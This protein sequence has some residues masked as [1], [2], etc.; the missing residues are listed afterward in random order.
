[1]LAG[2]VLGS[3]FPFVPLLILS[4]LILA[5]VSVAV[6]EGRGRLTA[7]QGTVLYGG[8]LAGILLWTASTSEGTES[9]LAAFDGQEAVA[10]T[11]T[12]AEP[13]RYAPARTVLVLSSLHFGEGAEPQAVPGKLRVTWREPDRAFSPGD[14][15]HL[16]ARIHLPSGTLNPGGFDYGGY[17]LRLG[18]DAVASVSGAGRVA[19]VAS[20]PRLSRWEPW[21][22]VEEWRGRIRDAALRTLPDPARGIYL[23]IIIGEQGYLSQD[24]RDAFMATGTV[25][26]LSI[27]GSHLGLVAWLSFFFVQGA[28]RLLPARWLLALSRRVTPTRLAAAA[29]IVLAVFYTLLAG[30]EVA[31]VRSLVMVAMFL[32][33]VWLGRARDLLRAVACAALLIVAQNPR[34]LFDISFQLSYL[35]ALTIALVVTRRSGEEADGLP[36][37]SLTPWE[38]AGRWAREYLWLTGGVTLATLPLVAYYFKQIAW[39]GLIANAV[40]VPLAGFVLVPLGLGSAVWLL[41]TGGD[42]LPA[43]AANE[44]MLDVFSGIV[45]LFAKLPGAEWHV[46]SPAL[47]AVVVFYGL[48]WM[49]TR[50]ARERQGIW[51]RWAGAAGV[52]V[53]LGWWAWSPRWSDGE[54]L[55][56]TFLDVGQGDACVL[57]LPDG[58][59]AL[60]DGGARYDTL[61]MGRAVVAPYLWERGIARLDHV[62]ATHPQLDHVGGLTWIV[63]S[64]DVGRYW[65]NGVARD[66][67]FYR[68]L[69]DV[70]RARGLMNER[71][72]EGRLV[73]ESGPCRLGILN[74]PPEPE[75]RARSRGTAGALSGSFLND[76]SVVATLECGVHS[77]LFTADVETG[78]L[79]RLH[80]RGAVSDATVVKVPHHGAASSLHE[81]WISGLKA[82][83]AIV[84]VGRHNAYGHP[85][86]SVVAAYERAGITLWR[87]DRDGA[88]WLTGRLSDPEL[89]IRTA[90]EYIL[91]PVPIGSRW[92]SVELSNWGRL[93]R[94]WTG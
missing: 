77:L 51:H 6:G 92:L 68:Q 62:I 37:R 18:I 45:A 34:A 80:Q 70:L 50:P 38:T 10:V 55:R 74:P 82:H 71:A 56:V 40:V 79:A 12:V 73:I 75:E 67:P 24:V 48:L 19:L 2:V 33:A 53:L 4:V 52:V 26:I 81:P 83:R 78:A 22:I 60:I 89:R 93:A 13:P 59:T 54:T 85:A 49:T 21:R 35:A 91:K 42:S 88:V 57:E 94:N 76:R 90:R 3:Y 11:G 43:A 86:A 84:S 61:D 5:A 30:A 15:V 16:T 39:V 25:H 36:P 47:A 1:V 7:R 72:A 23:G 58:Q 44:G 14:R 17:L 9:L 87:T 28:C 32:L 29:T 27:S 8:L 31:T 63:R 65:S 66:E 46:A 41:A 64:F 69:Q 20:P